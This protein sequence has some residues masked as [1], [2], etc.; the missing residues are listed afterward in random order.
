MTQEFLDRYRDDVRVGLA[1]ALHGDDETRRLLRYHVGLETTS[2]KPA[3]LLG[4]L[5]RPNLLLFV[6]EDLGAHLASALPAAV[7]LELVHN[8][9]LIHDDIEGGDE[10]RRGRT[11][12]G[13][14]AGIPKAVNA[15][16]L[17]L[18]VAL[19]E[20]S[21]CSSD[22][23][24]CLLDATRDLIDGQSLDLEFETRWIGPSEYRAMIQLKT[25]ALFRAAFELG[26]L[27]AEVPPET[28][29]RLASF[30]EELGMAYQIRNDILN[31]WGDQAELGR[32]VGV[33]LHRRKKTYPLVSAYENG[34]D[35]DRQFLEQKLRAVSLTES[36]V[37]RIFALLERLAVRADGEDAMQAHLQEAV[38]HLPY[39]PF[40]ENGLQVLTEL[41]D[42]LRAFMS[43]SGA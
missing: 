38:K 42:G 41:F 1:H 30:G 22:V 36:D 23:V 10:K 2:G 11:A 15:G 28:I 29:K 7:A 26:G 6:A 39:V 14:L 13:S 21:R 16:D 5:L 19:I 20:A 4:R 34:S 35:E 8:F 12:V 27:V 24:A 32:P 40:S 33:D 25:G 9:S 3:D 31:L 37:E 17:M 43:P 18:T